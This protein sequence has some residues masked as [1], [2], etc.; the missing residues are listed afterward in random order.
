ML[1]VIM[2]F[3]FFV[4]IIAIIGAIGFVIMTVGFNLFDGAFRL[5]FGIIGFLILIFAIKGC[6]G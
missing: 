4:G 1:D 3:A 2:M 6:M 5:I